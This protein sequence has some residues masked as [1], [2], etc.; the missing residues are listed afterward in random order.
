M[1]LVNEMVHVAPMWV[2]LLA[3]QQRQKSWRVHIR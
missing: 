1:V 3:I 2:R